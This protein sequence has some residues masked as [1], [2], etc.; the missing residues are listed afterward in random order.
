MHSAKKFVFSILALTIATPA[1]AAVGDTNFTAGQTDVSSCDVGVLGVDEGTANAT[2]Q[3][4]ANTYNCA[5][6]TYLPA[7]NS[8]TGDNQ[9]TPYSDGDAPIQCTQCPAGSYCG[10]NTFTYSTD[11]DQ[12]AYS[13]DDEYTG[14]T[15]AAGATSTEACYWANVSCPTISSATA[16]DPHAA[17]CA[18]TSQN[19]SGNFYPR[20]GI[21]TGSCAMDFTCAGGYTKST[22]QTVPTLPQTSQSG[23][24]YEYHSHDNNNVSSNGSSMSAGSWSVTWTSGTT[25]G[26]MGGIASCNNVPGDNSDWANNPSILPANSNLASTSTTGRYCWCKPTSWT[27]SGGDEQSL[28]AA[29]VFDVDNDDAGNCAIYCALGCADNVRYL[30]GFRGAL[31]GVVGASAQCVANTITLN[32]QDA[33]G[34]THA[35]NTCTYGG[36]ITTPTTAPTKRGHTFTG[37]H[38]VAPSQNSGS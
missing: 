3:W 5:A 13:C 10:G 16:C 22:T 2:P 1:I 23:N 27:P 9:Y 24:S 14:T 4:S 33:T 15:S 37:W 19:T 20:T 25:Q 21:Y 31:F 29:W 26:T 30:S 35:T 34:G 17:T 6:G 12:G 28:S 32:W 36:T 38:F 18:Y 8:W 11:E 7:G